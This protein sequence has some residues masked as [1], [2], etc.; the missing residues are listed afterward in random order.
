M[1]VKTESLPPELRV[2][3]FD[4]AE[5]L[6]LSEAILGY[7]KADKILMEDQQ[8]LELIAEANEL[9]RKVYGG[10]DSSRE[11]FKADITRLRELQ[12]EI[13]TNTTIQEQANARDFAVAFLRE[14]NQEISQLLG[15][16][17]AALSR[18]P[19]AGC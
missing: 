17:F 7:M 9:Q 3:S 19:G 18:R 13:S 8:A 2:A 10:G 12:G 14:I 1:K 16:D 6:A 4:L 15:V 5:S 11:D